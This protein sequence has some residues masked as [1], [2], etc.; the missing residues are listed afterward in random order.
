MSSVTLGRSRCFHGFSF[1]SCE[2]AGDGYS[3]DQCFST[4]SRHYNQH[5]GWLLRLIA[6][7]HPR[8]SDL[9]DLRWEPKCAFPAS[10]QVILLLWGPHIE[11]YLL[12]HLKILAN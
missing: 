5:R 2:L 6:E 11:N 4:F 3:V 7:P 9:I 1:F 10:S 8:I 12:D